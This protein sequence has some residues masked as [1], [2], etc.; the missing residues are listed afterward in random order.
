MS[1]RARLFVALILCAGPPAG[2]AKKFPPIVPTEGTVTINGKPLPNAAVTFVP[3]LEHFGAESYSTATTDGN[4]HFVLTCHFNNQPGA[5][6]GEHVVLIEEGALPE[7]MRGEQDGRVIDAYRA[8]L[9]NRPIP[10]EYS[11]FGKSP[12]RTE[13]KEGRGPVAVA[14]SR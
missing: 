10:P 11:S 13:V 4:G 9:G 3:V 7:K 2:C 1:L 8:K 12:L 6:V 5:A 14:I